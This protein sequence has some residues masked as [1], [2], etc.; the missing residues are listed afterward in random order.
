[1]PVPDAGA[2]ILLHSRVVSIPALAARCREETLRFLRREPRDDSFC[3]E[4]FSRA[5]ADRDHAAWE[6]IVDQYRAIVLA[7]VRQHAAAGSLGEPDDFWVN[8]AFQRFWLAVSPQRF[9][10]FRDLPAILKYLKLCVHSV[11]LDEVRARRAIQ[12]T[13]LEGLVSDAAAPGST[14]DA[15]LDSLVREQLWTAVL[16]Q[17]QTDAEREVAVLCVARG[18]KPAE[19][20]ARHPDLFAS[21]AEVYRVKRNLL[22]RLRRSPDIRAFLA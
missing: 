4:L 21:A 2:P 8:R 19:V 14:A 20:H 7:F 13:S 10:S 12:V 18:L 3:F 6:A 11:L 16:A 15:V 5:V 22:E 1:M 9:S 17:V